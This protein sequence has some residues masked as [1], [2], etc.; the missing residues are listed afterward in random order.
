MAYLRIICHLEESF[1][2]NFTD[3]ATSASLHSMLSVKYN[4]MYYKITFIM[5]R[6][7]MKILKIGKHCN[8]WQQQFLH[9]HAPIL[10]SWH[11]QCIKVLWN[12]TL[13]LCVRNIHLFY[14]ELSLTYV[15]KLEVRKTWLTS[16]FIYANLCVNF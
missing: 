13:Q 4:V 11:M 10:L 15:N 8:L 14:W 9:D 6:W 1:D 5:S 3:H 7:N 12:D 2:E 16:W